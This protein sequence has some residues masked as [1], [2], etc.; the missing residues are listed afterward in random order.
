MDNYVFRN[1]SIAARI[2]E[3]AIETSTRLAYIKK[4]DGKY[5]VKSKKSPDWNGGC[6][7]TK[8]EAS[9]RLQQVEAFKHM[10]GKGKGKKK[11]KKRK[12]GYDPGTL[13][14]QNLTSIRNNI[15]N[16]NSKGAIMALKNSILNATDLIEQTGDA[17]LVSSI[18]NLGI[19]IS[20]TP[21]VDEILD[22][23][24]LKDFMGGL[25]SAAKHKD[26]DAMEEIADNLTGITYSRMSVNLAAIAKRV[27][28]IIFK[29]L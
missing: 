5:C 17:S 6:Y 22:T 12:S 14:E 28:A 18:V 9:K 2:S 19:Q 20:K 29:I 13:V 10:K 1:A 27:A 3:L 15:S 11:G 21:G 25:A 8:E 23:A 4:E 26:L 24:A 7:D 16:R